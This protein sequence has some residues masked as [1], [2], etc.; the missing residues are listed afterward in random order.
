MTEALSLLLAWL[1]GAGIGVIFF[2]GLWWTL[3]RGLAS[4]RPALWFL[5]SWLLRMGMALATLYVLS[6]SEWRRL[7]LC[8]LG[9]VMARM[10][11]LRVMRFGAKHPV[12]R[13]QE[14]NR[15]P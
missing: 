9:F 3:R 8:L 5:G 11:M 12:M 2:G 1:G 10:V 6:G 13:I 7:L 15:A 14:A 4:P